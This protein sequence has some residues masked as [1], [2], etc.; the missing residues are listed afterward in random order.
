M[1]ARPSKNT[2]LSSSQTLVKPSL[3]IPTLTNSSKTNERTSRFRII[4]NFIVIW[5]DSTIS[6]SNEDTQNSIT[7]LRHII[8]SVET[9]TN[10]TEC[11]DF[12]KHIQNEKIFLIISGSL[13]E[14][15]LPLIEDN[16]QIDSIYIFCKNKTKHE[17]WA[18]QY[19]KIK[20]IFYHIELICNNLKRDVRQSES[21]LIPISI[22][23]TTSSL[24]MN[25]LNQSFMYSQLLKEILLYLPYNEISKKEL[26]DFCRKEYINN[27]YELKIIDEFEEKY[28]QPSP[29]WWYTR[30][31]FTYLMLNKALR[32]QDVEIIIKMGFFVRDIHQQIEQLY[33]QSKNIHSFIVYRG[34]GML[35]DE[36]EKLKKSKGCLLSFNNFLST[37]KTKRISMQFALQARRNPDLTAILFQIKINP[38]ISSTPFALL[39]KASYY[40]SSEKEILFSMHT[41]FRIGNIKQIKTRLWLVNLTLTSDNDEQLTQLTE[42]MRKTTQGPTGLH[43][44]GTL[45]IKMGEFNKA[46]EIFITLLNTTTNNDR[47]QLASLQNQ[48]G[49]INDEKGDLT[50]ALLHYRQSLE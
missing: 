45:M 27:H 37:S 34:Q 38:T 11:L 25:E 42:H 8:N 21:N 4:E 48:L 15:F 36:F 17:S 35:N 26:I 30:E 19:R 18:N 24:D 44:L 33:S 10:P 22:V 1:G 6:E 9:F 49:Y 23:S 12:I 29:I 3:N 31:C 5:L 40:L 16:I 2:K 39:D 41:I 43:R 7:Q 28:P 47:K 13:G 20:G 32:T 50:N 46:E 14:Q